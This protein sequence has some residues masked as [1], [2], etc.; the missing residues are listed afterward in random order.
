MKLAQLDV[1]LHSPTYTQQ[2][3]ASETEQTM[4]IHFETGVV[5]MNEMEVQLLCSPDW[6]R[7]WDR[8]LPYYKYFQIYLNLTRDEHEHVVNKEMDTY[9]RMWIERKCKE[10]T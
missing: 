1:Q 4:K 8:P 3:A 10:T 2:T 7:W 6:Q 9:T 5:A